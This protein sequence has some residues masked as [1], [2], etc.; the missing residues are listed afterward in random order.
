MEKTA[1]RDDIAKPA[2]SSP[3]KNGKKITL[4]TIGIPLALLVLL[5]LFFMPT[6]DGLSIEGQ[7]AIAIF[8]AALILWVCGSLPIYLTSMLV[9]VLLPMTGTVTKEKVVFGTLGYDVIWLMVS[10]FVL[11]SAMIKSNIARRFALW[12]IT[13]FGQTPKKA[14]FVLVLINFCIVFFVPSTTARATLMVPICMILLEVHKAIPGKSNY[15]KLMM[16]QGVQADALATSGVMTGT[17]AN[18]IAVGFINS[19]A[20]GSIGYIDWLIASFPLALIGMTLSFFVGLKLFSFKGEVDFEGSLKKLKKERSELGFLTLN[21]KKAMY[22]FLM[23][24]FL[25]ATESYHQDVVGFKISVYMTAVI[26]AILCLMPRIGLLTWN[27]AN[28]KWDLM[29]FAAGAYAAGNTLESTQGAQWLIGKMVYGLGLENMSTTMVYIVVVFIC[30]Y[31]HLIFT[32]KTVKTTIL[33][34]AIIALAKTLGMDPVTLALAASFTLTYT[35]TLPPHSKVNTIYFSTGYFSV[36]EQMKYG[37]I[38]CFIGASVISIAI[39]TWFQIL[40]YGL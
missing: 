38:T 3:K 20:G 8:C 37:L 2:P 27:E 12:M 22:I 16:L 9:I 24:V 30:M 25:W 13:N 29:I 35:I 26:A 11:T 21:E 4:K 34:P 5:A 32:S 31:S 39:F 23:T 1:K 17:A 36:L 10:A 15:G 19:Q 28:I 18:I 33:I 14:L 40:G 7:K 6:P